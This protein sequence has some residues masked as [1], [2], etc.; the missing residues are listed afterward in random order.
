MQVTELYSSLIW[1]PHLHGS[2]FHTYPP[3]MVLC[4]SASS[5]RDKTRSMPAQLTSHLQA[6]RRGSFT[7]TSASCIGLQS[8][9][10]VH[11]CSDGSG[12]HA[13][14]LPA[15]HACRLA[16]TTAACGANCFVTTAKLVFAY[17]ALP[18]VPAATKQLT[19]SS[20]EKVFRL[21]GSSRSR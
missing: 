2:L 14:N 12:R 17:P 13:V 7:L 16:H 21:D 15:T 10:A 19:R 11:S 18:Q 4:S 9:G 6:Y 3:C 1:N 20:T 5:S 8:F